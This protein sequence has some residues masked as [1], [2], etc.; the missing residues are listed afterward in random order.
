MYGPRYLAS[1]L[2]SRWRCEYFVCILGFLSCIDRD[3]GPLRPGV[4]RR[5][6]AGSGTMAAG[7]GRGTRVSGSTI[8]RRTTR[9]SRPNKKQNQRMPSL[10]QLLS[11][12]IQDPIPASQMPAD[13]AP[14]T[15][16]GR[17]QEQDQEQPRGFSVSAAPWAVFMK[18][19]MAGMRMMTRLPDFRRHSP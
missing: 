9:R 12:R 7:T 8:T 10:Q 4:K 2:P 6:M 1:A 16:L 15:A 13:Q 5:R 17:C 3:L 11:T 18:R 14:G 19:R